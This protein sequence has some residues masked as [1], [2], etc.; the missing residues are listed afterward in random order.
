MAEEQQNNQNSIFQGVLDAI[1]G[2]KRR[3]PEMPHTAQFSNQSGTGLISKD[4]NAIED[5]QQQYLDWQVNK[6]GHNLY[7]RTLYFDT[8]EEAL[9]E[10]E[11]LFNSCNLLKLK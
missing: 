10:Y 11:L 6:I 9:E 8:N 5:I 4:N 2:G 1:N 3:T 7:Q